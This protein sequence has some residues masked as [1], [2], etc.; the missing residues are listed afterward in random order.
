MRR[1][2][3]PSTSSAAP[4]ATDPAA[5]PTAV[6]LSDGEEYLAGLPLVDEEGNALTVQL[7]NGKRVLTVWAPESDSRLDDISDRLGAIEDHIKETKEP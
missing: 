6:R 5:N 3:P 1:S 7:R 4:S 2:L